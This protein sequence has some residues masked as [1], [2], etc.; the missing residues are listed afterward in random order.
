MPLW[1]WTNKRCFHVNIIMALILQPLM[2]QYLSDTHTHTHTRTHAH[3]HTHTRSLT[4]ETPQTYFR[5]HSVTPTGSS[6]TPPALSRLLPTR[7][8][9]AMTTPLQTPLMSGEGK[10]VIKKKKNPTNK[11]RLWCCTR[12]SHEWPTSGPGNE[13][14]RP[15][16]QA[17]TGWQ[18]KGYLLI[19]VTEG[20]REKRKEKKREKNGG[21]GKKEKIITKNILNKFK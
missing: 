15:L 19:E 4:P 16:S 5:D 18:K 21:K 20:T 7:V 12:Q 8:S 10:K 9:L 2:G 3:T 14:S 6:H 1:H 17:V 13:R 11:N